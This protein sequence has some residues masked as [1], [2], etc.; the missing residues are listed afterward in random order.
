MRCWWCCFQKKS[1]ILDT[2][3]GPVFSQGSGRI[4]QECSLVTYCTLYTF[5]EDTP[6]QTGCHAGQLAATRLNKFKLD[7]FK[8][9]KYLL[10]IWLNILG[11][12]VIEKIRIQNPRVKWHFCGV[13][14]K[15]RMIRFHSMRP[16]CAL[17]VAFWCERRDWDGTTFVERG[18]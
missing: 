16:G 11:H 3:V 9:Q 2:Q 7:P 5:Y 15:S 13:S 10:W 17:C 6:H 4:N 1:L 12:P 14:L 8:F 18:S